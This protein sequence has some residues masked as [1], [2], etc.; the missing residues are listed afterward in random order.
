MRMSIVYSEPLAWQASVTKRDRIGCDIYQ[1]MLRVSITLRQEPIGL[2]SSSISVRKGQKTPSLPRRCF[3]GFVTRSCRA[4]TRDEPLRTSA[5][6][7]RKSL[8][9]AC[10]NVQ[11]AILTSI[12]YTVTVSANLLQLSNKASSHVVIFNRSEN[13]E[14]TK[15][16]FFKA[17]CHRNPL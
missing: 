15:V 11:L 8:V 1:D 14:C 4:G 2:L 13:L 5:R 6:E 7:A 10:E 9:F 12:K 3:Q 16:F 17:E